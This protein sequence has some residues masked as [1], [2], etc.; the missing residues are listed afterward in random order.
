MESPPE[1]VF[2][3]MKPGER[4]RDCVASE[5]EGLETFFG[6]ITSCHVSVR[7]P[8]GR[9]RQGGRYEVS[10]HLGL[11]DG[12]KVSAR[13]PAR[14]EAHQDALIAI[15][16]VFSAARRQLQSKAHKL[17]GDVKRHEPPPVA[18]VRTL[19]PESD[20]GFLAT[21][22]GRDIYFHRNAVVNDGF[23]R[24]RVGDQITFVETMGEKGP[25]A[26]TV[27]RRGKTVRD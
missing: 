26:S 21:S 7:A 8:S 5:I 11:P 17:R 13:S 6:R 12:R 9:H 19:V 23:D 24:L 10:V 2:V 16:D 14:R 18:T 3:G 1:I 15:R 22:D 20:H 4:I 27:K 25:Q